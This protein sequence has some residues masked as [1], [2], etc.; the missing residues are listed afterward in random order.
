[1]RSNLSSVVLQL[2]FNLSLTVNGIHSAE[3]FGSVND[4]I[5]LNDF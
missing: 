4:F 3:I 1:M 2:K 5:A